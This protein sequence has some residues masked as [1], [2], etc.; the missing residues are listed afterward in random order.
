MADPCVKRHAKD[1][2]YFNRQNMTDRL[3]YCVTEPDTKTRKTLW[4]KS[5]TCSP[6][7]AGLA[8]P[9]LLEVESQSKLT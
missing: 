4:E 5:G 6:S 1:V 8:A 3:Q 9:P 7:L 2:E